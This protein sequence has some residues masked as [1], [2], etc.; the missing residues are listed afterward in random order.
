M[1][2]IN[3]RE[4][5]GCG[6]AISKITAYRVIGTLEQ[7]SKKNILQARRSVRLDDENRK[8]P[9]AILRSLPFADS[10]RNAI[11]NDIDR[12]ESATV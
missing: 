12:P 5:K 7:G 2:G 3:G 9:R 8:A 6:N 1:E 10:A 4:Y 11:A